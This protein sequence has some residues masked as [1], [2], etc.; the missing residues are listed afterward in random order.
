MEWKVHTI[1]E[2][3]NELDTRRILSIPISSQNRCDEITWAYSKDG[4]YSVKTAYML[5]K[6]CNLNTAHQAWSVIWGME[7]SPKARHFCWR[8]CTSTLPVRQ[9]LNRRH[10]IEDASCPCCNSH[11]E[12]IEHAIFECPEI[13]E[14]WKKCG[15][16]MMAN[17]DETG[18]MCDRVASWKKLDAKTKQKGLVKLNAD[19]SLSEDGWVG[20]GIVAR[21]NEG[22]VIFAA[23]RRVRAHWTPEVAEAKALVLAANLGKRYKLK[24]VILESDCLLIINRLSKGAIFLADLDSV[25]G[26]IFALCRCFNSVSWSHVRRVARHLAKLFPFG[27]EQVWENHCPD[28]ISPYVLMDILSLS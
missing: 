2:Y 11:V 10:L 14:L 13:I 28:E 8:L 25:L 26:D 22:G 17:W 24:D 1:E 21:N 6:S 18:I 16:L 23:T 5:G 19:A 27:I 9:L 7:I 20:L 4:T 3:F 12:S 15:V